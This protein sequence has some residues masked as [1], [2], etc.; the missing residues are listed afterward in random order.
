MPSLWLK[1]RVCRHQPHC[2]QYALEYLQTY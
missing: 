1:G 2:S